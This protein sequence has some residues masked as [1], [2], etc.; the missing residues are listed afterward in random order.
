MIPTVNW[1]RV[2]YKVLSALHPACWMDYSYD[3]EWDKELWDL[4]VAGQIKFA[5]DH[6]TALV[7]EHEVWI[8]NHPY[9]SGRQCKVLEADLGNSR[10]QCSRATALFLAHELKAARLI[11]RVMYTAEERQYFFVRRHLKGIGL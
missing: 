1:L 7:G 11:T 6:Y 9:A 2:K 5:D 3:P 8:A 4:L 10:P